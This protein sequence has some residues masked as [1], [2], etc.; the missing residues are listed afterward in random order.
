MTISRALITNFIKQHQPLVAGVLLTLLFSNLLNVLLPL[1]LGLFYEAGL[2]EQSLKGHLLHQIFPFVDSTTRF[3]IFFIGL[4]LLKSVLYFFEKY[5]TGLL[6]ERFSRSLREHVFAHQ[7]RMNLKEHRHRPTGKYLL[8]YSGDLNAIR[9]FVNRGI[10]LFTGDLFFLIGAFAALFTLQG[11]LTGVVLG[12]WLLA[13]GLVYILSRQLRLTTFDRRSQRSKG[14]GFVSERLQAFYTVKSFNRERQETARYEKESGRLFRF[15]LQ[16]FR[17]SALIQALFPFFFY[18]TLGLVLWLA[19]SSEHN[20]NHSDFFAFVLLLL[21][22]HT[23]L[24]RVLEVN[25]VWQSG[26]ASLIKLTN[27]LD[28][29]IEDRE[30]GSMP[31][32]MA[33]QIEFDRVCF[34]FDQGKNIL[35]E[36]QF[37]V[38]PRAITI[39]RGHYGTGK[40]TILKLIQKIYEPDSGVVLLDGVDIAGVSPFEV[41]KKVTIVSSEAPLL[42]KTVFQAISYSESPEQ[43]EKAIELLHKLDFLLGNSIEETLGYQLEEQARNL[44]SGQIAL[45]QIIRALLTEKRIILLDEPFVYLDSRQAGRVARLLNKL[46]TRHTILIICKRPPSRLEIDHIISLDIQHESEEPAA[47]QE[48]STIGH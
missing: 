28:K 25:L 3:F 18:G 45:L 35:P 47:D 17:Y 26:T 40:S 38:E 7:M 23:V 2:K 36:L 10:L 8:R 41:R 11:K 4:V 34:S 32:K 48:D 19:L 43:R 22:M 44:S 46:K 5:L 13:A 30:T 33:G 12:V 29:A 14:L 31:E 1:S 15:G 20:G 42:G 37:K 39:L 27:L 6:G 9:E 16:Y 24:Q 21:H